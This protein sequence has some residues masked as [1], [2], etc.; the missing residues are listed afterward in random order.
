[1]FMLQV[2]SLD[3]VVNQVIWPL[4]S[5]ILQRGDR[6][7]DYDDDHPTTRQQH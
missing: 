1:M 5:Q 4:R 7:I 6:L 3:R 2:R